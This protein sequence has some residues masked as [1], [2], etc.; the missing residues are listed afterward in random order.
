MAATEV[1]GANMKIELRDY[2]STDVFQE[3]VCEETLIFELNNDVSSTKTK[4]GVFKGI[5]VADFK[6]NGSGVCNVTP[7]G[8][9]YS[10]DELQTDQIALQKK[11]FVI[12][13]RAYDAYAEGQLIKMGG[14]GYFVASQFN[15]SNGEAC[16]FTWTLEGV[17]TLDTTESV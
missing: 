5:Q 3:M 9:E 1:Q 15:G 16:K 17:G 12:Q 13:N 6:A 10:Y 4:C 7:T 11:E 8:T 14:G 2:G